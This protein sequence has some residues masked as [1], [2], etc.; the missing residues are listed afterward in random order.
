M[1]DANAV[2]IKLPTFWTQQPEVWF[3]QV[4]AQF[5]IKKITDD[6]TKFYYIVSALDQATSSRVLDILSSPPTSDKY[7]A[8]KKKLLGS[9]GL[10]RRDRAHKLLH[11][12]Q[13]GDRKPSELMDEMLALLQGHGFCLLAEQLFLEQLPEELRIPVAALDFS[14]PRAVAVTADALWSAKQLSTSATIAKVTSQHNRTTQPP[15]GNTESQPSDKQDWCYYHRKFGDKSRKCTAPCQY[16]RTPGVSSMQGKSSSHLLYIRDTNTG[17]Q[18]LVDTGAEVSVFP[19][20]GRDTRAQRS[21]GELRTANGSICYTYGTRQL[22]ISVDGRTFLWSFVIADVTQPLL[23]ADFLCD[24]ELMVDLKG[25]RLVEATTFRSWQLH[26]SDVA[27]QRLHYVG[28]ENDYSA[29]LSSFPE[30]LTPAFAAPTAKHGVTHFIHTEGR[31]LHSR[32]R[33]LPPEKLNI[34][35]EE[36]RSMEDMG[37][38]RQSNSQWSSPLHMV[39]KNSGSWRPCGDYRRLNN[40]TTPDRYPIPHIQDLSANIAGAS[41]FS[42]VD[43]V[44][45]YHQIP[46]NPANVPKTAIITPFGLYKFLRM[47]FGLKNAAQ[48]FQR[49]MDMVC[50]GLDFVFVY[51][52]DILIFSHSSEQHKAHLQQLFKRLQEHGLVVSPAKCKFGVT[53]IDFLGHH[54]SKEG[55]KPLTEKVEAIQSFPIPTNVKQMQEYLGMMNFYNRFVPSAAEILQPLYAS[56]QRKEKLIAWTT[57]MEAAFT[58][59]KQALADA[60]LL[61]HPQ[62]EAQTSLTVDASDLAVGGVLEQLI[63]GVWRPLAFFS[64]K[65]RPAEVKY[66][67][68]DRELLG[69]YLAIRHFRYFLEARAFTIF[70]DHKPITL[71]FAKVSDPWSPRQQRHL[72]YISEFSTDIH[73]IA[74]KENRVAD[75]LS[76]TVINAVNTEIAVDYTA[77]AAAQ[78]NDEEIQVFREAVTGLKLEDIKFGPHEATL[79]CDTSLAQPRPIVPATWRRRVFKAVHD[80]SHPSIRATRTLVTQKFMW[81]GI[82]KDVSSWAKTCTSCQKAKVQRHV[83]AP[84]AQFTVPARRFDHINIDLVGPLPPSQGFTY[85]FTIVDRFTRWPEAV[86]LSDISTTSCAQ[87]LIRHWISRFGVPSEISSDR[88]PQFTSGLWAAVAQMLGTKHH[89]TTSHT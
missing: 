84:L 56:L 3:L 14:D 12:H 30:L 58:K 11:L 13:L 48:T 82:N 60:T 35:K 16:R 89:R 51:L 64:R 36:F 86:P 4:E 62:K 76:R 2:S 67:A 55:V 9:F 44:R 8:L 17:R 20:S 61:V 77:L 71:A 52:D 46:V 34:A 25:K 27:P 80:L 47:P 83:K 15:S 53:E 1:T 37:I 39:P 73:H 70:T 68:F 23:G 78:K 72:S 24:H 40:S 81:H 41:I 19:A 87:A 26:P 66:S 88:G 79:L 10:T 31:P 6:T 69:I 65:L 54:I 50:R 22:K 42:K 85:L 45:G 5:A 32:A 7:G 59:S 43:L 75:A 49:L 18:F 57:G 21:D 28:R 63:N 29:I 38:I 74:G 33:R